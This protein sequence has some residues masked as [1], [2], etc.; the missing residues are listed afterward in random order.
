MMILH[1]LI[2]LA[3]AYEVQGSSNV[4]TISDYDKR[5]AANIVDFLSAVNTTR[6]ASGEPTFVWDYVPGLR[7]TEE[8]ATGSV[9]FLCLSAAVSSLTQAGLDA[10]F[11]GTF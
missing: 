11:M 10:A 3:Q 7:V 2:R 9:V 5:I 6:A 4:A 8:A 1:G